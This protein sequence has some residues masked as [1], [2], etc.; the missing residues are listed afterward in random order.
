MTAE[1]LEKCAKAGFAAASV[2]TALTWET[3]TDAQ[4]ATW[5]RIAAAIIAQ[6]HIAES[7]ARV[8]EL[9]ALVT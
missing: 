5:R 4:R 1:R 7:E 9:A 2:G 3:A 8:A 6:W